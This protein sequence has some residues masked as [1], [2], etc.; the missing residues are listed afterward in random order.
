MAYDFFFFFLI[1]TGEKPNFTCIKY[2]IKYRIRSCDKH[3]KHCRRMGAIRKHG[4]KARNTILEKP[5]CWYEEGKWP[6]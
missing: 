2:R 6:L 5:K 4:E 1:W 3:R